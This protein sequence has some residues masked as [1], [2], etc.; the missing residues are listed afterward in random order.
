MSVEIDAELNCELNGRSFTVRSSDQR[1]LIE[2][3]DE[4]IGAN[5]LRAVNEKRSNFLKLKTI[6]AVCRHTSTTLEL[7]TQNKTL[8]AVGPTFG[9]WWLRIFGMP[10]LY[11]APKMLVF[12]LVPSLFR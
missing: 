7:R 9:V 12:K 5:L 1:V 6:S 10:N 2:V 4:Q 8:C 3:P 11:I